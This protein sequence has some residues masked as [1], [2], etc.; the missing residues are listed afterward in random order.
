MDPLFENKENFVVVL[1]R[2]G[3]RETVSTALSR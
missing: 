2:A 3:K 1:V